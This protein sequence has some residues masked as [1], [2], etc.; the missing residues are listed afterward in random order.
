MANNNHKMKGN[1]NKILKGI[2]NSNFYLV[3]RIAHFTQN[4]KY[5]L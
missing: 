3:L 2:Q 5:L 1:K 4:F